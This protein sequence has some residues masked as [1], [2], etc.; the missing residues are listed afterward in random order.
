M[1]NLKL[2]DGKFNPIEAKEILLNMISSKIQFHTIKDFS[3]QLRTGEFEINSRK[4]MQELKEARE[5]I[6]ALLDE[7]QKNN[8]LVDIQSTINISCTAENRTEKV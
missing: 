8:L 4:R 5:K 7:A 2:I 1:N 6:I 3:S